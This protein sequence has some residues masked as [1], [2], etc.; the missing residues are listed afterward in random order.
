MPGVLHFL[1]R[2]MSENICLM[3]PFEL[4]TLPTKCVAKKCQAVWPWEEEAQKKEKEM[5]SYATANVVTVDSQEA[6][7]RSYIRNRLWDIH[8]EHRSALKNKFGL[9]DDATPKTL[10]EFVQRIKDG[11]FVFDGDRAKT[12]YD[13]AELLRW[14]DPSVVE[15][16]DGYN[17]AKVFLDKALRTA[18]DA[19]AL[20]PIADAQVAMNAFEAWTLPTA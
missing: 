9:T 15:D 14:R 8:R 16:R 11:K 6:S 3:S 2:N 7:Q 19:A 20:S 1:G 17:A 13:V 5:S 10:N 18:E 4:D 12:G